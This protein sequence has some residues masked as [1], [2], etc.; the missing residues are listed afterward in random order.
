MRV[1][2]FGTD[3]RERMKE[4]FVIRFAVFVE[5][6][7]V[8]PEIEIDDHDAP[9]DR[10]AVH[11]LVRG[12]DGVALGAGRFYRRDARTAQIGRM[13]I[14][15]AAR[16]AGA[17]RVLLDALVDEARRRG[18][19]EVS[20]DAQDH[21]V[22]FYVKAAFEPYGDMHADAGIMHQPMRRAL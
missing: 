2:L 12:D 17:G 6:Q 9:A 4:A 7:R 11:A 10:E 20:L 21:A 1:E 5:E 13:A 8:P 3:D 15:K 16:R 19:A 14:A 22:G 18:Y